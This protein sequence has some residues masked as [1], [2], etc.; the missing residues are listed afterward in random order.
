MGQK[1]NPISQRL[2]IVRS[3]QSEWCTKKKNYKTWF[4][5]ELFFKFYLRFF[6]QSFGIIAS[7]VF[8]TK[9]RHFC[10]VFCLICKETDNFLSRKKELTGT[11]LLHKSFFY[12]TQKYTIYNHFFNKNLFF[13][14]FFFFT[15]FSFLKQKQILY[16]DFFICGLMSTELLRS[17]EILL[18]F[19]K[20]R[21]FLSKYFG[22]NKFQILF[23]KIVVEFVLSKSIKG[24][25]FQ[26]SGRVKTG[27]TIAQTDTFSQGA[28][29]CQQFSSKLEFKKI[30]V[31]TKY[32]S[33]GIQIWISFLNLK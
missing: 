12:Q 26:N 27:Q 20:N 13:Y 8:Y 9:N 1:I 19:L 16:F 25:R 14:S 3:W 6:F 11:K 30:A 31:N 5:K 2:G 33:V 23:K 15:F 28:L 32:G 4:Q 21:M 22:Q 29:S 24:F 10:F 17:A 7:P 18:S